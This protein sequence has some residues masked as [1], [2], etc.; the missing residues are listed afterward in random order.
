MIT[1]AKVRKLVTEKESSVDHEEDREDSNIVFSSDE[2][3]VSKANIMPI[4]RNLTTYSSNSRSVSFLRNETRRS[5]V[6]SKGVS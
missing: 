6:G 5:V 2:G 4:K 1:H 3:T